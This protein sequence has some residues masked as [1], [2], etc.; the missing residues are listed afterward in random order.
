MSLTSAAQDRAYGCPS[1]RSDIPC[2]PVTKRSL[3]DAQNYGDDVPAQDLINPPAFSDL[4]IGPLA[5]DELRAK[6]KIQDLFTRIGYK[7]DQPTFDML[8]DKAS[9]DGRYCTVN[10]FRDALNDYIITNDLVTMK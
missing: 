6:S 2:L 3:A 1:I 5:M 7:L 4:S 8:F 10:A 9:R